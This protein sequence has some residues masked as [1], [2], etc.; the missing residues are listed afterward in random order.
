MMATA[1]RLEVY[2]WRSGSKKDCTRRWSI[3]ATLLS[4]PS[5][6]A[7]AAVILS[8]RSCSHAKRAW[9]PP[10]TGGGWD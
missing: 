3:A 2:P 7:V 5:S 10:V 6:A 1:A 4:S 9:R 8:C